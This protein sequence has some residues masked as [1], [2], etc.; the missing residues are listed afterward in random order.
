MLSS[1]WGSVRPTTTRGMSP[2]SPAISSTPHTHPRS[3]AMPTPDI[4]EFT[5]AIR[6]HGRHT[7]S[8]KQNTQNCMGARGHA[9]RRPRDRHEAYGRGDRHR[10]VRTGDVL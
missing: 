9:T 2:L 7:P 8:E 4:F 1:P 6:A 3:Y 5:P 10:F